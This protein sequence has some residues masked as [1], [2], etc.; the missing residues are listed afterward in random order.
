MAIAR[1]DRRP[2]TMAMSIVN[3][4]AHSGIPGQKKP[5]AVTMQ[6]P[7]ILMAMVVAN[8][9]DGTPSDRAAFFGTAS[10]CLPFSILS[11]LGIGVD[12][13]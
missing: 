9:A 11:F 4:A 7:T 10:L 13:P 12:L 1:Y 2:V 6:A 8:P 5:I 3:P